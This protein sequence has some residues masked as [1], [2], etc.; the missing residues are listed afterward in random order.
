VP[1]AR[2]KLAFM[3]LLQPAPA[4]RLATCGIR[5]L[6]FSTS[7][8]E[9]ILEY[10]RFSFLSFLSVLGLTAFFFF[11][12]LFFPE[13]DSTP[14]PYSLSLRP[15]LPTTQLTR[16][17]TFSLFLL[18]CFFFS[19]NGFLFFS[20]WSLVWCWVVIHCSVCLSP[21]YAVSPSL[22]FFALFLT[23]SSLFFNP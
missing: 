21:L 6:H 10:E 8:L 9:R 3:T 5:P 19:P 7:L 1:A 13:Q 11:F 17:P 18:L 22:N 16:Q 2:T 14:L 12:F 15:N 4:R 23:A 20:G